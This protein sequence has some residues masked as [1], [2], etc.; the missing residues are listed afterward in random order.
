[1]S[2]RGDLLS[3]TVSLS[4]TLQRL[5]NILPKSV[6]KRKLRA[7]PEADFRII[8]TPDR[9][10]RPVLPSEAPS[11]I[12]CLNDIKSWQQ[13]GSRQ[14]KPIIEKQDNRQDHL[15]SVR[16]TGISLHDA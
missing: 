6:E 1:M 11:D 13:A 3:R 15:A 16:Y 12:D 14:E 5:N 10:C 2:S 9:P 8:H 4:Q 7:E